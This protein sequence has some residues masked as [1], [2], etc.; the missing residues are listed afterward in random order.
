MQNMISLLLE[1]QLDSV[2]EECLLSHYGEE[3]HQLL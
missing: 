3:I 2:W 1:F